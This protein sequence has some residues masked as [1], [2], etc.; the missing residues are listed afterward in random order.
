MF[1]DRMILVEP[2]VCHTKLAGYVTCG[3]WK[4][5]LNDTCWVTMTFDARP[6]E[7]VVPSY[8]LP[9]S[10]FAFDLPHLDSHVVCVV[11][12]MALNVDAAAAAAS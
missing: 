1:V 3:P 4:V 5:F 2:W 8:H 12:N 10:I 9:V 11:N 6:G 7:I